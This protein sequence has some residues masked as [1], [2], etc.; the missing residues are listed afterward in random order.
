MQ[1]PYWRLSGIYFWYFSLV[2]V[3]SP[4]LGL[5]FDFLGFDPRQIGILVALPYLTKLVAPNIWSW[6]SDKY[7]LR[8]VMVR[9]GLVGAFVF[10][11]GVLFF[12]DFYSIAFLL[13]F[14]GVFSNAILPQVEAITL[15]YLGREAERYSRIRLWG[16]VGFIGAVLA[17]GLFFDLYSIAWL[18]LSVLAALFFTFIFSLTLPKLSAARP[19][20]SGGSFFSQVMKKHVIVFYL[21]LFFLQFSH[22]A[23]Y[24]FYSIYLEDHGYT[25]SAIGLLWAIAVI[26]EI[27]IFFK[28]PFIFNRYSKLDLLRFSLLLT[29]LR[30]VLIGTF[31]SNIYVSLLAQVLHAFSFGMVHALAIDFI[32]T[33]FDERVQGQAQAFY[34][35]ISFGAG[36]SLGA[37]S[38]GYIWSF[39]PSVVFIVSAFVALISWFLTIFI[40]KPKNI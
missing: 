25:K 9:C 39:S 17:L 28:I 13:I 7:G 12:Q 4:Y 24:A 1:L 35:A 32:K 14:F 31:V 38:A 21:I 11:A 20:W 29:V 10:F 8:I 16:S 30:W 6:I 3:L 40:L 27:F 2:G 5:Y 15:S 26:C 19:L 36:A 33:T 18:P 22:G 23:Y 34:S 37:L